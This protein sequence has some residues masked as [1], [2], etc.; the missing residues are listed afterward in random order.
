MTP[1]EHE[2]LKEVHRHLFEPTRE[3]RAS[4]A[5]EIDDLLDLARA[6]KVGSR[7]VLWLSSFLAGIGVIWATASG[8]FMK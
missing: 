1:D 6:S 3:G 7:A 2:M 4:R 8:W 5:E